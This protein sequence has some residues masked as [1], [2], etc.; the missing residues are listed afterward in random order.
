[1]NIKKINFFVTIIF[2]LSYFL[3]GIKTF[4]DFGVN[5]EEHTQ[6]YSGFYWLN[7]IYNFFLVILDYIKMTSLLKLSKL[8]SRGILSISGPDVYK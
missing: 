6:V 7:Y 8:S 2:F 1:M 4:K 3:I 5:I